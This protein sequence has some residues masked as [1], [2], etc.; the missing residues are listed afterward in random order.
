VHRAVLEGREDQASD[1]A[2]PNDRPATAG[3][4]EHVAEGEIGAV[5]AGTAGSPAAPKVA[6]KLGAELR[7]KIIRGTVPHA[8]A[9]MPGA[10][11]VERAV[12]AAGTVCVLVEHPVLPVSVFPVSG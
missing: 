9:A 8:A 5:P 10:M 3:P 1:L 12:L 6:T 4:T 2:A 11:V 7:L